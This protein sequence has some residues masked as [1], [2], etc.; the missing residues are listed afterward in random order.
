M[1]GA[2]EF[3]RSMPGYEATPLRAA[4]G[5]A[6]A[7]GVA[8]LLVKDESSRLGLPAFKILGASWA[9]D[10][11]L[12]ALLGL[13]PAEHF[14]ELRERA[15]RL[16]PLTL[17]TATDGNHGRAV[18]RVAALLGLGARIYMPQGTVPARIDAIRGEG[19]D[20]SVVDGPYDEAVERA[21][22]DADEQHLIISD[23]SWPGYERIPGRVIEGYQTIAD[24]I[25]DDLE[26]SGA[27]RPDV[28]LAQVGV[29][30]FAATVATHFGGRGARVVG[31]EPDDAACL[32]ESLE[33]GR[34]VTVPGPHRSIMAGLNCGTLSLVAWPALQSGIDLALT[35]DDDLCRR[36]MVLLA[37][38]GITSGESGAAGLAGLLRLMGDAGLAAARQR[39][40]IGADS[41]VL[42]FS[43]EGPTDPEAY[44]KA[45]SG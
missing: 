31:V 4:P 27:P 2:R 34:R 22:R 3:H 13:E 33:A 44:A 18:A 29:G 11:A 36:A 37:A 26:R 15:G 23:T 40:G 35:V 1:S 32:L 24:E 19:A 12:S 20:V 7:A 45:V 28:V 21:A 38:D 42:V 16:G 41:R 43:T 25:E 10:D 39:L 8:S 17:V 6:R 14:E 9:I 30:A 5:A